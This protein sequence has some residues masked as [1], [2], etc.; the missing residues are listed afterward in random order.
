MYYIFII[1][2]Q[3]VQ[4]LIYIVLHIEILFDRIN[5]ILS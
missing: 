5:N 2:Y 4:I 3:I 1:Q